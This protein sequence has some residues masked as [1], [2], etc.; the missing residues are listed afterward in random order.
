MTIAGRRKLRN[1]TGFCERCKVRITIGD[2]RPNSVWPQRLRLTEDQMA[3][4]MAAAAEYR[5]L[6]DEEGEYENAIEFVDWLSVDV[7]EEG[8]A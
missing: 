7:L 6:C 8:A 2:P 1:R 4:L 3:D 5:E